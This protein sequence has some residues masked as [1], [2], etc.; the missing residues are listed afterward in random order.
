MQ[1]YQRR[2]TIQKTVKAGK[3][4]AK[5]IFFIIFFHCLSHIGTVFLHIYQNDIII[6]VINMMFYRMSTHQR[7][8]NSNVKESKIVNMSLGKAGR[9][10]VMFWYFK[11]FPMTNL[12]TIGLKQMLI[13]TIKITTMS[14]FLFKYNLKRNTSN[15]PALQITHSMEV[16]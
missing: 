14:K 13:N 7:P 15:L 16:Y 12:K 11:F 5:F 6:V 10:A 8:I 1:L 4:K 9:A 2:Y 3:P